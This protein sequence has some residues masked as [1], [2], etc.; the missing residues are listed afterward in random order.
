M[1]KLL[2]ILIVILGYTVLGQSQKVVLSIDPERADVG[3]TFTITV[4]SYVQGDLE[5]DNKPSSFV[6]GYDIMNGMEQ[7]INPST[8]K[9]KTFYYLSQTGSIGE[10]G[11]YTIGPAFIKQGNK[12]YQSNTVDLTIE[13]KTQMTEHKAT[14]AQINAG[15][16]GVI[17]TNKNVIY[18][19]EPVLISAKIYSHF[20]PT[21]LSNYKSYSIKGTN[22][23]AVK[24][25]QRI[26]ITRE[27][28]NQSKLYAFEYD[29]NIVFPSGIGEFN[30]SNYTLDL[31]RGYDGYSIR[32]N[33]AV[34]K[35]LPLPGAPPTDFID[36]VGE[37]SLTRTIEAQKM[38]QGDVFKMNILVEGIGNLQNITAP[39][40]ILP[41]GLVVYGDPI[42]KENYS[43]NTHGAEGSVSYEYNI[44][45]A[46]SGDIKL[47]AVTISYFDPSNKK[48]IQSKS[49]V[50]NI[51]VKGDESYAAQ[52]IPQIQTLK[53]STIEELPYSSARREPAVVK[54]ERVVFGTPLF[55]TG[56]GLPLFTAFIFIL[57]RR[58]KES[59]VDQATQNERVKQK[60][61]ALKTSLSRIELAIHQND[62]DVFFMGIE[63][64]LIKAF[65]IKL[66]TNDEHILNKIEIYDHLSTLNKTVLLGRIRHLF[67]TA[68]QFRYGVP[69][70]TESK[71]KLYSQLKDILIEINA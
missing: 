21:H 2:T 6:P 60:I 36:G 25:S 33:Q 34:V 50:E 66:D 51:H 14:S 7:E 12:V 71:Q 62:D 10:P 44:Q 22:K 53:S 20:E 38:K 45:V 5:V 52:N 27:K 48:Y 9:V 47:P 15:V 58:K 46:T 19:G 31:H 16:F 55:F 42:I 39:E 13:E 54:K 70:S 61:T 69:S 17:Q 8:G 11:K 18:E 29:K 35:V 4:K 65:E 57:I 40:P 26:I 23:Q 1:Y 37:F 28:F 32:S 30:I 43:Y 49:H 68:D 56:I 41:E 24:N 64:S 63:N 67:T 3:E 59:T